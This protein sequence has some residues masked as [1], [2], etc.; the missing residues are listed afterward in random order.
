[1]DFFSSEIIFIVAVYLRLSKEDGDLDTAGKSESNSIQNQKA[2][3]LN[4]LKKLPNVKIY[5]IYVDDG[6]T[7]TNF[8][9]PDFK[10]MKRD[11]LEGR[12]NM[13]VV[14]DL[15]RFGRDYVEAGNYVRN[16]FRNL[17]IRFVS[18]LDH[19]DS[20]TATSTDYNLLLP[21]KNFVNDQYSSDISTKVRGNQGDM[22]EAG[23][24]IGPYV[25]YGFLKSPQDKHIIIVDEYAWE[26]IMRMVDWKYAG[27]SNQRIADQLNATGVLSP[28][29][30]KRTLGCNYKSGFQT[31][32][33]AKWTSVAV[34]RVLSN[35]MNKGIMIQGKR[36]RINYKVRKVIE[37]PQEQWNIKHNAVVTP[38]PLLCYDNV[39]RLLE[40]D[41]RVAPGQENVYLFAGMV[42]CA[43]CGRSM[44]RRKTNENIF[45]ICTT[46]NR[47]D[48]CSRHS[49]PNEKLKEVVLQT[50]RQYIETLME[51]D[52]ILTYLDTLDIKESEIILYDEE[53]QSKYKELERYARLLTSLCVDRQDGV[54]S[55]AEF[56]EFKGVYEEKS[57]E[58]E[59]N[60]AELKKRIQKMLDGRGAKREWIEQFKEYRNV[61]ELD[62]IMLVLLVEKV[63]V[64]EKNRV[65]II[66]RFK[67]EFETTM[68]YIRT[69]ERCGRLTPSKEADER[70]VV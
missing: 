58:L 53:I 45:Y 66:F 51:T 5:D 60:I 18:V 1:M 31:K 67:D 59:K 65:E 36:K 2:L 3:I 8:D 16:I 7:G 62:R 23:K 63:L 32:N 28:A 47:G 6:Y 15:S 9:R 4:F 25:G 24:Y 42:Y 20:L 30:Y 27:F 35:P 17:N 55:D 46:Y 44:T 10:R 41:I 49:I 64:Y 38:M 21:V 14:K 11:F 56:V 68:N 22:R 54:V 40:Q 26:I 52:E 29:E 19:F 33:K 70:V 13:V 61:N 50:I 48:G 12:V 43:D 34:K 57:I 39:Q 69:M 37:K